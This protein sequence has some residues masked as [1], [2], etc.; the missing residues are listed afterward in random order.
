MV[1]GFQVLDLSKEL[2]FRI[3]IVNGIP[4]SLSCIPGSTRNNFPDSGIWIPPH[5]AVFF[6]AHYTKVIAYP[7]NTTEMAPYLHSNHSPV[8][9]GF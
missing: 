5:R 7:S 1:S 4:D 6:L 2:G 8:L 9:F 3:S